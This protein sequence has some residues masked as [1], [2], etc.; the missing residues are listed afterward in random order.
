MVRRHGWQLPAH[1]FQVVAIT[2]FFLLA[3]AFY[4]FFAPFLGSAVLYYAALAVYSPL[5]LSVF[6]L[7]VRS[8][9]IDPSDPGILS[10]D[11]IKYELNPDKAGYLTSSPQA[12]V[13]RSP[14]LSASPRN[15]SAVQSDNDFKKSASWTEEGRWNLASDI[16]AN[17][18]SG[19]C[20]C[21]HLLC[22]WLVKGDN[23][24]NVGKQQQQ[25]VA[26]EDIL[27][28]TLC[29]AEVRKFSKHCRNCDKCV[30]GF[31]HHCRWL[32]NCVG[33][34]NYVTFVSLMA[35]SLLLLVLDWGIGMV[36]FVRCFVDKRGIE[37]EIIDKLGN[38]FPR[39][40]FA[41]VVVLCTLVSLLA[42][43]P[44]AELFFFHIIL[45]RKGITTYEYV[46]AMRAQ[47]EVQGIAD[48]EQQSMP[49]SPTSSTATG[50]S[51]SSSLGLQYR[52]AWCTPPRV[53]VEHQDEV[54][55]HLAPGSI[56]S[57][58]DPDASNVDVK[59]ESRSQKHAVRISAWK[60]A[61][62]NPNEATQAAAKARESSSVLRPLKTRDVSIAETDYSSS[63]SSRSSMSTE[64]GPTAISW[65]ERRE[66]VGCSPQRAVHPTNHGTQK[67]LVD[68][69]TQSSYSSPGHVAVNVSTVLSGGRAGTSKVPCFSRVSQSPGEMLNPNMASKVTPKHSLAIDPVTAV[70]QRSVEHPSCVGATSSVEIVD[71]AVIRNDRQDKV[72]QMNRNIREGK[73]T[74]VF[75]D[76]GAGRFTCVTRKIDPIYSSGP[77]GEKPWI[78]D[79]VCST[80]ALE[81]AASE[82]APQI[83]PSAITAMGGLSSG[84][85]LAFPP[86]SL[87]YSGTSIFFGGPLCIPVSATRRGNSAVANPASRP[88]VDNQTTMP[89]NIA[90]DN[91]P[92]QESILRSRSP[93]F[94][95]RFMQ[96]AGT[97]MS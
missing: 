89:K 20:S 83:P 5:A 57:T 96:Q 42:S 93:V 9:A 46:V 72:S 55:P 51:G 70:S 76:R 26:D 75:W 12:G 31:D 25:P 66:A 34:K 21:T 80:L 36:V 82:A 79:G 28:C 17:K 94:V 90:Q 67:D 43:I 10:N 41:A 63:I 61:K 77:L 85:S 23:C 18:R 15:S 74:A 49:S 45:I 13:D 60:L 2:V 27:F 35:T 91:E 33:R 1:A 38:G 8:A 81:D 88:S 48:G 39:V 69:N 84:S 92:V 37:R 4:V 86:E 54:V 97:G 14:G 87:L 6:L 16:E 95:P 44:L 50:L 62:L 65:K 59:R 30:D 52:G 11:G 29:N 24:R 64:F 40:P 7:Y 73:R 56:P 19:S 32:N 68:T 78:D 22:G 53:F 47:N 71:D 58:V 3:L